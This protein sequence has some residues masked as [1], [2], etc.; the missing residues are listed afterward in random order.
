MGGRTVWTAFGKRAPRG[1]DSGEGDRLV[2]KY[3]EGPIGNDQH[4]NRGVGICLLVLPGQII[5]FSGTAKTN[6]RPPGASMN[7]VEAEVS[8]ATVG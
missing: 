3:A 5:A 8:L 1:V 2:G 6:G 7:G 4:R